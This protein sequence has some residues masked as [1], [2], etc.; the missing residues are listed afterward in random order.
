MLSLSYQFFLLLGVVSDIR[1]KK[2]FK[3]KF[4]TNKI[5]FCLKKNCK[6]FKYFLNF[7]IKYKIVLQHSTPAKM[8]FIWQYQKPFPFLFFAIFHWISWFTSTK[9]KLHKLI[10]KREKEKKRKTNICDKRK[11]IFKAL[12][13]RSIELLTPL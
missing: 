12:F 1:S 2:C 13:L 11:F 4:L 10:A 5:Y 7:I 6:F 8:F 3:S 9:T